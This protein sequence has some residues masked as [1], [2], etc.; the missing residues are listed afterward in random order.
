MAGS[1]FGRLS[2]EDEG[3]LDGLDLQLPG[4]GKAVLGRA[5]LGQVQ[6]TEGWGR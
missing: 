3:S 5:G 6:G 1:L 4:E 2:L